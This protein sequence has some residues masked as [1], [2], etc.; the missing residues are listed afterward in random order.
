MFHYC[1][2]SNGKKYS[3]ATWANDKTSCLRLA[4]CVFKQHNL[5][6]GVA[7]WDSVTEQ[8]MYAGKMNLPIFLFLSD[9][10]RDANKYHHFELIRSY[11]GLWG[12]SKTREQLAEDWQEDSEKIE[13]L[14]EFFKNT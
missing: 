8:K 14:H 9:S 1:I 7:E 12:A 11:V 10:L 6:G 13:D 2:K 5:T 4:E 3:L